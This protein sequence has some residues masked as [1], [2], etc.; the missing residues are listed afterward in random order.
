[1]NIMYRCETGTNIQLSA[2]GIRQEDA[3]TTFEA[4]PVYSIR[5]P[6]A[7]N[8]VSLAARISAQGELA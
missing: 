8:V 7:V 5:L 6:K 2:S 1:M 4:K 3:K